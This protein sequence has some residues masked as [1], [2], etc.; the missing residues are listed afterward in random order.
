ME[1][2]T[3][4]DFIDAEVGIAATREIVYKVKKSVD[5]GMDTESQEGRGG[6]RSYIDTFLA[7]SHSFMFP[8][9]AARH[10]KGSEGKNGFWSNGGPVNG[11]CRSRFLIKRSDQLAVS[12][13]FQRLL[14]CFYFDSTAYV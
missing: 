3:R 4:A 13:S 6:S 10:V 8:G 12:A 7:S 9:Q 1:P 14:A 2:A 11:G 5:W